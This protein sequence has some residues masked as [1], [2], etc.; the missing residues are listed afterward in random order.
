MGCDV[1]SVGAFDVAVSR[2]TGRLRRSGRAAVGRHDT[3][4]PHI[5]PDEAWED[6]LQEALAAA[7]RKRGQFD[8]RR[9]SLRVWLLAIVADQA[10]KQRRRTRPALELAD[11]PAP[12]AD[13][14]TDVDLHAALARLSDRQ[15]TTLTLYYYVG[16]PVAEVA[17][18]L[19]CRPGTVKSTLADARRRLRDLLGEDY[20]DA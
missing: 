16:L 13:P 10:H 2:P 1:T 4:R 6:V 18:V 3:F 8:S 12:R 5:A 19:G 14:D 7:W 9:G 20:R 11:A 17:E 15:R